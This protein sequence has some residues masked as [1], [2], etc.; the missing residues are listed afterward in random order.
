[1]ILPTKHIPIDRSL[2]GVGAEILD[3]LSE[4]K[5]VSTLWND[6]QLRRGDRVG[7]LPYDWFLLALG[8]LFT[9]DALTFD[10]GKLF[11]RDRS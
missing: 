5:T 7:R 10:R 6:L 3:E 9:L 2:L 4:S 8:F 11:K 1:M